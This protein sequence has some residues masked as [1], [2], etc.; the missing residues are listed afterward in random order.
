MRVGSTA[1]PTEP[2]QLSTV[3]DVSS[4]PESENS[5]SPQE[6]RVILPLLAP[7]TLDALGK[8]EVLFLS[9]NSIKSHLLTQQLD[10]MSHVTTFFLSK[11]KFNISPLLQYL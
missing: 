10:L 4:G 11:R 1:A 8:C 3:C 5:Q 9:S 7:A 2:Q 6:R